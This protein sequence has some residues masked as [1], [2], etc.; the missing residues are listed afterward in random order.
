MATKEGIDYFEDLCA[1]VKQLHDDT[2][3]VK[4][5]YDEVKSSINDADN[6]AKAALKECKKALSDA[7]QLNNT[8]ETDYSILKD[9]GK[10]Q[11]SIDKR[12]DDI[13]MRMEDLMKAI[14]S[15]PL[16]VHT[17]NNP[18]KKPV[19][20]SQNNASIKTVKMDYNIELN[21]IELRFN[22]RPVDE[23]LNELKAHRF[24]WNSPAKCWYVRRNDTS[25]KF[26][27]AFCE[28]YNAQSNPAPKDTS[29][30]D[31]LPF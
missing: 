14:E 6:H 7:Q 30:D 5:M 19:P 31:E 2:E 24:R 21:G 28:K 15:Q 18:P 23:V 11:K 17:P 12:F 8:T 27:I 25:E 9:F 3:K 22:S 1:M 16:I 20:V 26:A 13:E 10:Y 29:F 4:A